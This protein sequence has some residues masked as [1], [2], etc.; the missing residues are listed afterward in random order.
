MG[1]KEPKLEMFRGSQRIQLGSIPPMEQSS[2]KA[3]QYYQKGP[4]TMWVF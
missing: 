2:R 3:G 4:E 1:E